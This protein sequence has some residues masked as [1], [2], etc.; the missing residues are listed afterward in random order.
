VQVCWGRDG[1]CQGR[2]VYGTAAV[3]SGMCFC[4]TQETVSKTVLLEKL[5]A[6]ALKG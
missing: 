4:A 3:V 2:R 1:G 5:A 6:T